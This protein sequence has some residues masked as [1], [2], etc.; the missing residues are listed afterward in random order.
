MMI[1]LLSGRN[2]IIL[3]LSETSKNLSSQTVPKP[4]DPHRNGYKQ[5]EICVIGVILK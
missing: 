1:Q 4:A 5:T 2:S 3:R